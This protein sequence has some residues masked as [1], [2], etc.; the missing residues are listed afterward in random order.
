MESFKHSNN[1]RK[2]VDVLLSGITLETGSFF[3]NEGIQ[4]FAAIYLYT[5]CETRRNAQLCYMHQ[6]SPRLANFG[7]DSFVCLPVFICWWCSCTIVSL[8][9]IMDHNTSWGI[10]TGTTDIVPWTF[11]MTG[12][13]FGTTTVIQR[14]MID[15]SPKILDSALV[16]H[17]AIS[18]KN[19]LAP[20]LQLHCKSAQ[21]V[22]VSINN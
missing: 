4:V 9:L 16:V 14:I 2:V 6:K 22:G 7:C 11:Q 13:D 21:S 3:G 20:V 12:L 19:W 5:C 1:R 17:V 8:D 10:V 18:G 15:R